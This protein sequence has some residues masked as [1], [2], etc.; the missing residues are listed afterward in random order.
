LLKIDKKLKV[1]ESTFLHTEENFAFSSHELTYFIGL[2]TSKNFQAVVNLCNQFRK[3]NY[4]LHHRYII[5]ASKFV[6]EQ[7]LFDSGFRTV[8]EDL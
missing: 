1:Q 5:P 6:I 7:G 2:L 4:I 8:K 3:N